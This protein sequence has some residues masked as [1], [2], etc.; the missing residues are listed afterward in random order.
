M[1]SFTVPYTRSEVV[2]PY[3]VSYTSS[4]LFTCF[5][6]TPCAI[7]PVGAIVSLQRSATKRISKVVISAPCRMP[8]AYPA[9]VLNGEYHILW[10]ENPGLF[11]LYNPEAPP[12]AT[13][14]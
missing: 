14:T 6:P 10:R 1:F 12:V 8:I 4:R 5:A 11:G 7:V 13:M 3:L 9:P 2:S